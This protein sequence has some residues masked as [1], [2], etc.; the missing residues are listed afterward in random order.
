MSTP[1]R[2]PGDSS[3]LSGLRSSL[4]TCSGHP[5]TWRLRTREAGADQGDL[6]RQRRFKAWAR[7]LSWAGG[8]VSAVG[9]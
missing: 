5:V 4:K 6:A 7:E 1:P 3:E 2:L 8:V 9:P